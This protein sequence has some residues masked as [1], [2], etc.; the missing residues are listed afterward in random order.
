MSPTAPKRPRSAKSK[1]TEKGDA[2]REV[3]YKNFVVKP[4]V[5][6]KAISVSQ[7]KTILG[8]QEEAE[9]VKFGTDFLLK[10]LHGKKI[11]CTN[12]VTNRPLYRAVYETLKQEHLRRRWKLNAE[13]IILGRTR[14][15]LNGQHAL[16]SLILAGQEW[17]TNRDKWEPYWETEPTMEKVV[18]MGVAEDDETVN[19]MDTCK[20][21]TLGEV[22]YRSAYFARIVPKQRKNL[23][24]I[25]DYA[26][27][28]M[29]HRTGAKLNAYAPLRTHAESLD[30]LARHERL[31]KCVEHIHEENGKNLIGKYLSLG[32]AAGLLYLMATGETD[33]SK[34]RVDANPHEGQLDFALWDEACDFWVE[35]AGR[36][37]KLAALIQSLIKLANDEEGSSKAEREAMIVKAWLLYAQKKPITAADL[38][39]KYHKD[40]EG[41][42]SLI[43]CP[44]AGGIDVGGPDE[45]DDPVGD[46]PS[47]QEIKQR[48][49][50][51][52][53]EK[54]A[55]EKKAEKPKSKKKT[56]PKPG[57]PRV[58]T[59]TWVIADSHGEPYQ[60][61]IVDL[62]LKAAKVKVEQGYRGAGNVQ[63][64]PLVDLRAKQPK[65][66]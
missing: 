55:A 27:R 26:I 41:Y 16:I 34:Y 24:R 40:D 2:P 7:A 3:C 14:L 5:G 32:A 6:D 37:E 22:I 29:W 61:R 48:T 11:R 31:L 65:P 33:P 36:T 57:T 12:N 54:K 35:V 51:L 46:D 21:R 8:W 45:V 60:G 4:F 18:A 20:P 42:R 66:S 43:E 1:T 63:T 39:L 47:P 9:K 62:T 44:T 58:G 30:F 13:P 56:K 25:A 50:E 59:M 19:T 38:K 49:A 64:V 17:A 28:Q 53:K 52:Q 15:V 23:A 10:D